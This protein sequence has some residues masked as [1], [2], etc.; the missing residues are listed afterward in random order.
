MIQRGFAFSKKSFDI[1]LHENKSKYILYGYSTKEGV[2]TSGIFLYAS[3]SF[4]EV[5]LEMRLNIHKLE[6]LF[7]SGH[8]IT[9]VENK[10]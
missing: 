3:P 6:R 5:L 7:I 1:F 2:L 4:K 8:G 9:L 10:V